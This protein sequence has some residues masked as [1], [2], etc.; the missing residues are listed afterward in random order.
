MVPPTSTPIPT[1]IAEAPPIYEITFDGSACLSTAPAVL[2]SERY[3]FAYKITDETVEDLN[4]T[5]LDKGHTLKENMDLQSEPG[6]YFPKPDWARDARLVGKEWNE[7]YDAEVVTFSL[8][9]EG[10]YAVTIGGYNPNSA[11]FCPPIEIQ[12]ELSD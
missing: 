2:L 6:D 10:V 4:I 9:L 5:L 1:N 8:K 7:T 3:S 12:G 11:W